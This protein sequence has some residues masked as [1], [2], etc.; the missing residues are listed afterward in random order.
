MEIFRFRNVEESDCRMLW[1]WNNDPKVREMAFHSNP[2]SWDY[3]QAWFKDKLTDPNYVIYI[4]LNEEEV[5]VGEAR[6]DFSGQSQAEISIMIANPWR[7]KGY[8]KEVILSGVEKV[9]AS[10][11]IHTLHAY[12]KPENTASLKSFEKAGF[13]NLGPR[14]IKEFPAIHFS[15]KKNE[16]HGR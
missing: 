1:V 7:Q 4:V 10:T 6:F 2:I 8:G 5:P 12:I 9:F 16:R 14:Q 15:L 13:V 11:S 3:Y